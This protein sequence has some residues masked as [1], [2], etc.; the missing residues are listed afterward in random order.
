MIGTLFATVM[1]ESWALLIILIFA[2]I[3]L[4]IQIVT[5]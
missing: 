3:G 1:L 2:S 4:F 5:R